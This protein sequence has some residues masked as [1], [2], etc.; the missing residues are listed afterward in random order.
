MIALVRPLF[1]VA[2]AAAATWWVL[3]RPTEAPASMPPLRVA[4]E[5]IAAEV[6]AERPAAP[7]VASAVEEPAPEPSS[8]SSP[9]PPERGVPDGMGATGALSDAG[10][11]RGADAAPAAQLRRPRRATR[12][13]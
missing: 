6:L 9:P 2:L 7:P 13:G 12:C 4:L 11:D 1:F 10:V 8:G 5:T 3:L